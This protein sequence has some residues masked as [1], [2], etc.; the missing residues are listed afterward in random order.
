MRLAGRLAIGAAMT[1]TL[2]VG[3]YLL[4]RD[5]SLVAVEDVEVVGARGPEAD[6]VRRALEGAARDMTTLHVRE[7]ALERAVQTY[8]TVRGLRV[9]RDLPHGLRITVLRRRVIANVT[10]PGGR[11]VAVAEDGTLLPRTTPPRNVP[12]LKVANPPAGSRLTGDARA[13]QALELIAAAPEAMRRH[14]ARVG[15]GPEGL[16]AV[17]RNGPQI[18]V[19]DD[20]RLRAKWVAAAR[21]LGDPGAQGARYVD[22]RLPERPVAGGLPETQPSTTG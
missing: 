12:S 13:A 2:L 22:V 3:A 16:E 4:V 10:T 8:A 11:R 15:T 6:G 5:S 9:Q 1:L 19:G 14:V 18:V 17:L 7:E 21:V 20:T